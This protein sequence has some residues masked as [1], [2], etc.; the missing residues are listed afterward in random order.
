MKHLNDTPL[1]WAASLIAI[2]CSTFRALNWGYQSASYLLSIV[3]YLVFIVFAKKQS[4]VFLNVFYI[5][6][7]L[8]GAWQWS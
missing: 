5:A 3:A 7:A 2:L 4:Q 1:E 8:L 6:T